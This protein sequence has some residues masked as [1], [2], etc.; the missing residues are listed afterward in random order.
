MRRSSASRGEVGKR[1]SGNQTPA[2]CQIYDVLHTDRPWIVME[3]VPSR[4]L[5]D[6]VARDGPLT[7]RQTALVGLGMLAGLRAAHRAG[8]LHRDVKP[9][10]VLIDADDRVVL[11]DFGLAALDGGGAITLADALLGSPHFIAPERVRDG[12]STT[13][14]DMW[15]LGATLYLAVEGRPPYQR[16]TV[17]ATLMALAEQPPDPMQRAGPLA[18]ILEQLLDKNPERRADADTVRQWLTPIAHRQ[19]TPVSGERHTARR[20]PR[21]PGWRTRLRIAAAGG[22]LAAVAAAGVAAYAAGK[23]SPTTGQVASAAGTGGPLPA[24]PCLTAPSEPDTVP[25]SSAPSTAPPTAWTSC[26]RTSLTTKT[27]TASSPPRKGWP[28]TATFTSR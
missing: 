19:V 25:E 13:A 5:H 23:P 27:A 14:A 21:T 24:H 17:T 8:V 4:S 26:A 9:H 22:V 18:P 6:I 1:I 7:V 3:Y 20:T 28:S 10:N 11:T 12:V 2:C 15:S 16:P